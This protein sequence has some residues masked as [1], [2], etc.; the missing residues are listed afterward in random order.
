[1][2][3]VGPDAGQSVDQIARMLRRPPGAVDALLGSLGGESS[4]SLGDKLRRCWEVERAL[5]SSGEPRTD[6]RYSRSSL[7]IAH[8]SMSSG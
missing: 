7:A 1:M 4:A 2:L 3:N 8:G 6:F 5:K